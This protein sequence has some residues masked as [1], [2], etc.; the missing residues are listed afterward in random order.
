[1]KGELCALC[2]A[3]SDL[4]GRSIAGRLLSR[5]AMLDCSGNLVQ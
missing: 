1:M 4:D 3:S 2:A 5:A